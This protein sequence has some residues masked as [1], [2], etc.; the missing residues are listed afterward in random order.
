MFEAPTAPKLQPTLFKECKNYEESSTPLLF[1]N[2]DKFI[3]FSDGSRTTVA[4]ILSGKE[5]LRLSP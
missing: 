1:S 5:V 2:N 3:G 4:D